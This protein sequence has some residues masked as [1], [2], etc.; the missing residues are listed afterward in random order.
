MTQ[1][2]RVLRCCECKIFQV[3][4]VKKS[5]KW[6]CKVCGTKQS[7]RQVYGKGTG[8]EC[9]RH[10]Q[11]LNTLRG[12]QAL[13]QDATFS[14][15]TSADSEDI[16]GNTLNE[17]VSLSSR[18]PSTDS[19]GSRWSKFLQDQNDHSESTSKDLKEDW[20]TFPHVG[21]PEVTKPNP[22][23]RCG[24]TT[25]TTG[26]TYR[27][28]SQKGKKQHLTKSVLQETTI[29]QSENSMT[30]GNQV[31]EVSLGTKPNSFT[32]VHEKSKWTHLVK[33]LDSNKC[34]SEDSRAQK[35]C[36]PIIN[37][38]S[39]WSHFIQR[40]KSSEEE[41][42]CRKTGLGDVSDIQNVKNTRPTDVNHKGF[43]FILKASLQSKSSDFSTDF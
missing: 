22:V 27:G 21:L 39:K 37:K 23:F 43:Q 35:L 38:N 11:K 31:N 28:I 12:V 24:V 10:V 3:H 26:T 17:P 5:N 33:T 19:K 29:K 41:D 40:S 7:V 36:K 13:E 20:Q 9:R 25:G 42:D 32:S 34:V 1:D 30:F 6:N 2:F 14:Q 18:E 4:Q 16:W 15:P 8:A